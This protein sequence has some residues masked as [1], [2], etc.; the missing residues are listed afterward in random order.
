MAR[1]GTGLAGRL[2]W[3]SVNGRLG[4]LVLDG[5]PVP[6]TTQQVGW[7]E[8]PDADAGRPVRADLD[9]DLMLIDQGRQRVRPEQSVRIE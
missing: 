3:S 2:C 7:I 1:S 8:L 6:G 9:P 4:V 5:E